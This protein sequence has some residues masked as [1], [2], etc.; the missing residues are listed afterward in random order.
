MSH[1]LATV[2]LLIPIVALPV[3]V[4]VGPWMLQ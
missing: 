2:L 4:L 3:A 1:I